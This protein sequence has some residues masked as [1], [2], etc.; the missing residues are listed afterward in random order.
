MTDTTDLVDAQV[1][2][3]A[4]RDLDR[5]MAFYA[6]EVKIRAFDGTVLMDGPE[7]M[8]DSY[9][10]LFRDSPNLKVAITQ[11]IVIGEF[12]V[13]EEEIDGF[14]LPG[15]PTQMRAVVVYR[16]SG[17]KIQEVVLLN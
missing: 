9:G 5:F 4:D 2:A 16:V 6:P 3:Y 8:R 15:F 7:S 1:A 11:R 17:G 12:V 10:Q 14:T 13:D